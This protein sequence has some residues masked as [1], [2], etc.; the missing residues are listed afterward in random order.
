MQKPTLEQVTAYIVDTY[1]PRAIILHGSRANGMAKEHSDWDI[2]L[3]TDSGAKPQ[4][5]IVFGANLEYS[6]IR[7]PILEDK[8][9]PFQYRTENS[10]VLYDPENITEKLLAKIDALYQKGKSFT[11]KDR[12]ARRS[13]LLSSLDGIADYADNPLIMFDKKTD[14]YTRINLS[15]YQFMKKE[16]CPSPYIAYPRIQKDDPEFYTL[17]QGFVAASTSTELIAIGNKI[18]EKLFPDLVSDQA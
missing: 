11:E 8:E 15:W 5:E 2:L 12:I 6:E 4:R 7:L 1:K 16:Y 3:I 18:V 14:F 9:Y 17:I 10:K 13:Y